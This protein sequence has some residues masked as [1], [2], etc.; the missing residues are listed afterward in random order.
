ME[1]H[2][3]H[4]H[5][6]RPRRTFVSANTRLEGWRQQQ[7]AQMPATAS[8]ARARSHRRSLL[9]NSRQGQHHLE[10]RPSI[11]CQPSQVMSAPPQSTP[12]QSRA[13]WAFPSPAPSDPSV[14]IF[15]ILTPP[16]PLSPRPPCFPSRHRRALFHPTRSRH[17]LTPHSFLSAHSAKERG[18]H[19][20]RLS[21]L[22][23]SPRIA[24]RRAPPTSPTVGL[25]PSSDP[26]RSPKTC[27][28]PF[29]GRPLVTVAL[30]ELRA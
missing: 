10:A 22:L 29:Q 16:P 8:T 2:P 3:P 15:G 4:P 17:R 13:R 5:R 21:V 20:R 14:P 30:T 27:V 26:L 23:F 11:A 18:T 12:F 24:E 28:G 1:P 7:C 19:P 25:R 9:E 6:A